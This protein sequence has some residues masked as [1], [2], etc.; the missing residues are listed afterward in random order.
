MSSHPRRREQRHGKSARR[1]QCLNPWPTIHLKI[2]LDHSQQS[3]RPCRRLHRRNY[4][5]REASFSPDRIH[6]RLDM[7]GIAAQTIAVMNQY[8]DDRLFAVFSLCQYFRLLI[9]T[10]SKNPFPDHRLQAVRSPVWKKTSIFLKFS[11]PPISKQER[12]NIRPCSRL[13]FRIS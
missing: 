9:R 2:A 8:P 13:L 4:R 10:A 5:Q 1:D 3:I 11:T 6:Q 12:R 7:T